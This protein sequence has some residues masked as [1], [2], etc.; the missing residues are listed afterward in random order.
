M[1]IPILLFLQ[2]RTYWQVP[3]DTLA[4]GHPKHTHVQTVGRVKYCVNEDDW[5]KH[6]RLLSLTDSTRYITVEWIPT[7]D[8][9]LKVWIKPKVRCPPAGSK[10]RVFGITRNDPEHLWAEI[11][12]AEKNWVKEP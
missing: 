8:D 10:I 1:I 11:H 6:I 3:L 2:V 12:P 5:D 7:W 9:S 4:I